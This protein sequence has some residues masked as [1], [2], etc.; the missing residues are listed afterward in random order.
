MKPMTR[1]ALIACLSLVPYCAIA[2]EALL[3]DNARIVSKLKS[4][5]SNP[6]NVAAARI[7]TPREIA[8][9]APPAGA[10][11]AFEK[12]RYCEANVVLANGQTDTI[13]FRLNVINGGKVQDWVEPCYKR[14]HDKSMLSDGCV[15]HR[16]KK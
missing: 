6:E 16:P 13:Y 14:L 12:S 3:C 9:G 7:D 4:G 15:D 2:G 8:Y 5:Y 10:R 1:H 11:I